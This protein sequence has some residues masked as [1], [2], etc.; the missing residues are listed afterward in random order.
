MGEGLHF[1]DLIFYAIIA[2]FLIARLRSVLGRRTGYKQ[3]HRS[4]PLSR[5]NGGQREK[6][7]SDL[8]HNVAKVVTRAALPPS[9]TPLEV[10]LVQIQIADPRFSTES[11]L[12]G[13]QI[14]FQTIINAFTAGELSVLRPLLS[15]TVFDNF[16]RAI[17]ARVHTDQ[18]AH[19]QLL[20]IPKVEILSAKMQEWTALI[21]LRFFSE[22]SNI[23]QSPNGQAA[24]GVQNAVY[25]VVDIW[26]FARDLRKTDPNW[27]LVQTR[28]EH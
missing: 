16:S 1:I 22:Q 25:E 15:D 10:A 26:T 27:T 6:E 3:S 24:N 23:G 20:R 11:F 7:S 9:A 14:A 18:S 19:T 28:S 12:Q 8:T 17:D 21:T 2:A 4:R 5:S 13:A